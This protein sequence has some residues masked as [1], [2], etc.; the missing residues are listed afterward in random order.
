MGEQR[1]ILHC[2]LNSFYA[3]VACRQQ[4]QLRLVPMVVGGNEENRHGIVLAANPL[5]KALGIRTAETLAEARKKCATLAVVPPDY[6]AYHQISRAVRKI[7]LRYTSQV[8][9]Y[10]IDE[11][12]LDVTA[13]RK[14]YGE[15]EKIAHEIRRAVHAEQGVTISAGVSFTKVFA[16]LGSDM[17]KPD[18]VTVIRPQDVKTKVWPLPVGELL[19][20]GRSTRQRLWK[21][22]ILTIGELANASPIV[23][24]QLLG[25]HGKELWAS[26]NGFAAG[27][28]AE[29]G[30]A[31]PPKSIG[32]STTTPRDLSTREDVA[33]VLYALADTVGARLR[34]ECV[35][36]ETIS[37]WMRDKQLASQVRQ[38]GM[39]R[40][41]CSQ[42]LA[43]YA[44][45]LLDQTWDGRVLRA[46]G[47]TVSHLSQ[48]TQPDQLTLF[49][50]TKNE[51]RL[52]LERSM[53]RLNR[54]Y[55]DGAVQRAVFFTDPHLGEALNLGSLSAMGILPHPGGDR[56][57]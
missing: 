50:D 5:A 28:V 13:S 6:A 20:V 1:V 45:T 7:Y 35:M 10:G 18:A 9:P 52:Q 3:S 12:W 31:P 49:A 51:K 53:D 43:K 33:Y 46:V 23:L 26:A 2:D 39:P 29:Y 54:R 25:K 8:E 17:K 21:A 34:E 37:I 14:L 15:G 32:N 19:Y 44:L 42:V 4:P 57:S 30:T 16:K 27:H 55:G 56:G 41:Q 40:T 11:A 24:E 36:G 48:D 38:M 22:N 47:I